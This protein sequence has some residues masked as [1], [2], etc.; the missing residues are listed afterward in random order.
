MQCG[1]ALTGTGVALKIKHHNKEK[2]LLRLKWTRSISNHQRGYLSTSDSSLH[3]PRESRDGIRL[4]SRPEK[5]Q[6]AP[7]M[8]DNREWLAPKLLH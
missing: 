7:S 5:I 6:L 1:M 3:I 8:S 4:D 2:S